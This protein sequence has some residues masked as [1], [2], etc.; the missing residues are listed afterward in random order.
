MSSKNT[1]RSVSRPMYAWK[2]VFV[3]L[4]LFF[5]LGIY[6]AA[7]N[8]SSQ[9][10]KRIRNGLILGI[11]GLLLCIWMVFSLRRAMPG[12]RFDLQALSKSMGS[13]IFP[14]CIWLVGLSLIVLGCMLFFQGRQDTLLLTYLKTDQ[15]LD[16]ED[17]TLLLYTG[18]AGCFDRIERLVEDHLLEDRQVCYSAQKPVLLPKS[19][20]PRSVRVS[21]YL[22]DPAYSG[23][24]PPSEKESKCAVF[25]KKILKK[26]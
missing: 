2:F 10:D 13:S 20:N 11:L 3:F 21:D 24:Y 19:G 6:L 7:V 14:L 12:G 15:I 9:K 5:P 4:V 1:D 23:P 17:L 16:L 8:L 22:Q 25:L 26:E 18:P